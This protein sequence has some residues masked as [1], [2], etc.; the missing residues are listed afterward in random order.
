MSGTDEVPSS[1]IHDEQNSS[2]PIARP[3]LGN[4]PAAPLLSPPEELSRF[5]ALIELGFVFFVLF[6]PFVMRNFFFGMD[7]S[8]LAGKLGREL[9][10]MLILNGLLVVVLVFFILHKDRHSL[11]SFGLH[12]DRLGG[13][14]ISAFL[15]LALIGVFLGLLAL[16]LQFLVSA[17]TMRK[18]AEER[19]KVQQIFP[20]L[21]AGLLFL[22]SLFIGF[23]EEL[24]FRGFVITRLKSFFGSAWVAVVVSSVIFGLVH[25]YQGWL[26]MSQIC[27]VALILGGLYVR[28]GSLVS[29]IIV[30]TLFDFIMLLIVLRMPKIPLDQIRFH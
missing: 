28:R 5:E 8:E 7:T 23:Y 30:H 27:V 21:N 29:P 22:I 15:S 9:Y 12:L 2:L 25:G 20:P 4:S 18:I 13:E 6:L 24:F 1:D 16:A 17:E 14:F 19:M 11:R 26:A 10:L 3:I